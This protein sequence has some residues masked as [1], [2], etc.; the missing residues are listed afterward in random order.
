M[1]RLGRY[2]PGST[3]LVVAALVVGAAGAIACDFQLRP[4]TPTPTLVPVSTPAATPTSEPTST[5]AR[6]PAAYGPEE[7]AITSM[8]TSRAPQTGQVVIAVAEVPAGIPDYDRDDWRHWTD[9][10]RDCMNTR[11]EVL[12]EESLGEVTF[13]DS[14]R[15]S[16]LTGEWY[17]A[18]TSRT[19]TDASDLDVDHF[20]P[21]SNA[22][23]SGAWGWS[24]EK[25]RMFANS[26]DDPGHL[27]AVENSA[28]RAK[29]DKG[30]ERWRPSN[31]AFWCEYA[32]TW[33]RIKHEW[34]LTATSAEASA[35]KE[36]L[37]TC[38]DSPQVVLVD[39]DPDTR[40]IAP[41]PTA[42]P[43]ESGTYLS[44]DDAEQAG[45]AR[46]RGEKGSGRGFPKELVP[47]ARDGDGD[48]VVCEK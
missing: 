16:V 26:L 27:I 36:M 12:L 45:V 11:H 44:C 17:G 28:N 21:L 13:K 34:D 37:G 10:D 29:G 41:T 9:E 7:T 3:V 2:L 35:L 22:H 1:H 15:C 4:L 48:G 18:F 47:S 33:A 8:E 30:P 14:R 42:L 19:F 38:P 32:E 40:L 39:P 23:R 31:R 43:S 24:A 20:V 25:K 46:V 6:T 5:W